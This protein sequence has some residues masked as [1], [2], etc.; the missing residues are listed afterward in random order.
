[1]VSRLFGRNRLLFH[2]NIVT[3][4]HCDVFIDKLEFCHDVN[5]HGRLEV[6]DPTVPLAE[7]LLEKMQI[8]KLNQKDI[9]DTIMLVREHELGD[10]DNETINAGYIARLCAADW[11]LWK[12][13][14]TNLGRVRKSVE[15]ER[16]L[17]DE[18]KNDVISKVEKL[19]TRVNYE[20]KT[21]S[22]KL[23][24]RVGERRKWYRDVEEMTRV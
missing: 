5:F 11:G 22:W 7:L 16:K 14:T 23:R 12:T 6:D 17:S 13:L 24:A 19:S 20:P 15:E 18:D 1:M 9:V 2:D 3:K 21:T 4:R 8:V 10:S